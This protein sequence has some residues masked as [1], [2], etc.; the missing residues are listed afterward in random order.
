MKS[1]TFTLDEIMSG[2]DREPAALLK[3][4]GDRID[5]LCLQTDG[6]YRIPSDCPQSMVIIKMVIR[7]RER[8]RQH[9]LPGYAATA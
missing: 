3:E 5:Y 4:I 1:E 6:T 7:L 2:C 9:G 8:T